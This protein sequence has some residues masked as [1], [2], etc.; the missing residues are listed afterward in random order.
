M[1]RRFQANFY[2]IFNKLQL[3]PVTNGNANA[4]ANIQN[5][6]FG[7][8]QKTVARQGDRIPRSIPGLSLQ[9]PLDATRIQRNS[10]S[11]HI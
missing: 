5:Q 9:T 1:L 10:F 6:F 4:A 3:L 11:S 2:N 8:A 7:I